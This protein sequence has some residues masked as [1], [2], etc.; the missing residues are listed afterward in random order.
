MNHV[1]RRHTLDNFIIIL[2][3][4]LYNFIFF[5]ILRLPSIDSSETLWMITRSN[6]YIFASYML[7]LPYTVGFN[8]DKVCSL[9][10]SLR[11]RDGIL[12]LV[13]KGQSLRI[14]HAPAHRR[15]QD[16]SLYAKRDVQNRWNHT[17]ALFNPLPPAPPPLFDTLILPHIMCLF[18]C[19]MCV[20]C[21]LN[22]MQARLKYAG[23][24]GQLL[25]NFSS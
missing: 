3:R 1:I 16:P 17:F 7:H 19:K 15:A 12:R 20:R 14:N 9:R 2:V 21:L 4:T 5:I 6:E 22:Q 23:D 10:S 18:A 11:F 24:V 13:C 25:L 8:R